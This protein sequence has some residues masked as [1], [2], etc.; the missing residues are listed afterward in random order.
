MKKKLF[1][2]PL[3]CCIFIVSSFYTKASAYDTNLPV[4][5]LNCKAFFKLLRTPTPKNVTN[6]NYSYNTVSSRIPT[7]VYYQKNVDL[8]MGEATIKSNGCGMAACYNASNLLDDQTAV[9]ERRKIN[10]LPNYIKIAE[11]NGYF[12]SIQEKK[13][14]DLASILIQ[15]YGSNTLEKYYI[16]VLIRFIGSLGSPSANEIASKFITSYAKKYTKVGSLGTDPYAIPDILKKGNLVKASSPLSYADLNMMV[17]TALTRDKSFKVFIVCFWNC[18]TLKECLDQ[19]TS[20]HFICFYTK[21]GSLY[22]YNNGHNT[23]APYQ[24]TSLYSMIGGSNRYIV[25]YCITRQ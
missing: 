14:P 12:L 10:R 23:N 3:L 18:D 2:L 16:N 17:N 15:S 11:Q 7:Y 1:I 19:G 25:G 6:S 5:K 9:R 8:K 4:S 22:S 20:A 24:E 21:N 13:I